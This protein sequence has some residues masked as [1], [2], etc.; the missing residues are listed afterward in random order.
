LCVALILV[1]GIL[2][3]WGSY[4]CSSAVGI[5]LLSAGHGWRGKGIRGGL[6]FGCANFTLNTWFYHG[7]DHYPYTTI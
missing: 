5:R 4:I 6:F 2:D 3:E 7:L 1:G